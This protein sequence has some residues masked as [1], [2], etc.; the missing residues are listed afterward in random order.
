MDILPVCFDLPSSIFI[1]LLPAVP[2]AKMDT[3]LA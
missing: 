3:G 1:R 2:L